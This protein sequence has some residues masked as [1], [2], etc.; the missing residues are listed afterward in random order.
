MNKKELFFR[1]RTLQKIR[2]TS[3]SGNKANLFKYWKSNSPIHEDTKYAIYK[4][5]IDEGWT[6]YVE[7]ELIGKKG[8]LDLLAIQGQ[9]AVIIEV[10]HS[11][12]Q[13]KLLEKVKKYPDLE[14]VS[15]STKDFKIEDFDL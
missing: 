3:R 7:C 15:V 5:L 13:I 2:F 9:R 4:K 10:L 12:T 8:R 1:N 11:E 14:L 6:V